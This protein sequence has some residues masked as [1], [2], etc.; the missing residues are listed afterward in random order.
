MLALA[1]P[2]PAQSV[3]LVWNFTWVKPTSSSLSALEPSVCVQ[4]KAVP[5][6]G[7]LFVS[8]SLLSSAAR[9]GSDL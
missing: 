7:E 8:T 2:M 6:K 9:S 3:E 1:S 4:L 5:R